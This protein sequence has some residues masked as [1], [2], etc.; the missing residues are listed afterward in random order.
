MFKNAEDAYD[1]GPGLEL[2][3]ADYIAAQGGTYTPYTDGRIT[4]K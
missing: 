1:F 2:V 3:V 4:A